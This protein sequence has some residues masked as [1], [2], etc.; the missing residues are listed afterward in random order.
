MAEYEAEVR[1]RGKG[2]NETR[3][4]KSEER[5]K[6]NVEI[7]EVDYNAL[8]YE[9]DNQS[10]E[11]LSKKQ[12]PSLVQYPLPGAINLKGTSLKKRRSST[13]ETDTTESKKDALVQNARS[14]V[15]AMALGVQIKTGEDS[16][17]GDSKISG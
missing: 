9:Q 7:K 10:D 17:V 16:I 6:E 4:D 15:L 3:E 14:D 11:D 2:D 5:G 1:Q 12:V 8:D 13:S